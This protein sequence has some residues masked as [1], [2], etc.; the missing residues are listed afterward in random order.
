MERQVSSRVQVDI[1]ILLFYV[2]FD[3]YLHSNGKLGFIITQSIFQSVIAGRGF[4]RFKLPNGNDISVSHV[5][6][7]TEMQPFEG[8]TNRTSVIIAS[9]NRPTKYPIKYTIWRRNQKGWQPSTDISLSEVLRETRTIHFVAQPIQEKDNLSAWLIGKEKAIQHLS[10]CIGRSYYYEF[11]R[12]GSDTR[13][14][15]AVYWLSV[16]HRRPDGYYVVS[17]LSESGRKGTEAIQTSI[18]TTYVYPLLR[19][20]DVDRWNAQPSAFILVPYS[21]INASEPVTEAALQTNAPKT[22][23]YLKFFKDE[24]RKRPKF[25]NFDPANDCF[26]MLYN[27]G[28]Y[29]F[30]E[31]KVVWREQASKFTAAV[32]GLLNG[33]ITIPDHKLS[34]VPVSSEDEAYYLCALLNS[35]IAQFIVKSYSLGTSTD[36]HVLNY[37]ACPRFNNRSTIHMSLSTLSRKAHV[38]TGEGKISDLHEIENEID[39]LSAQLWLLS[40][41]ELS[42]IQASLAELI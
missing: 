18:E 10:K 19:G 38:V 42:E 7:L 3:R 11:A 22:H 40:E 9:G 12:K 39:K 32:S 27:I 16:D 4:R 5:D 17:N 15:N 37:I 34:I 24:L 30:S 23:E 26:Y 28:N 41:Q 6:D 14:A 25:R 36:V 20:R 29:S 1:S 21:R 8:A 35:S 31:Y 13:G 2:C 33:E